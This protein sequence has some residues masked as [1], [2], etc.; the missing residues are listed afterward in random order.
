MKYNVFVG[1]A[2]IVI[3]ISA[4]AR[5]PTSSATDTVVTSSPQANLLSA[6]VADDV[7]TLE[8]QIHGLQ[9]QSV[10]DL[11]NMICMPYI[12]TRENVPL[13]FFYSEGHLPDKT[14]GDTVLVYKYHLKQPLPQVLHLNILLTL[15]PCG[16]DFQESNVPPYDA[17]L[18]ASYEMQ[19]VVNIP[20]RP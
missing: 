14:E 3:F 13:A 10:S 18:V 20:K 8:F 2:L 9:A 1:L 7:L 15:G 4:C 16:P 11:D 17:D 6:S 19:T 12:N 5:Q